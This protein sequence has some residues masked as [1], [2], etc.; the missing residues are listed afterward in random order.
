M[1]ARQL[2]RKHIAVHNS[3]NG[4]GIKRASE[5]PKLTRPDIDD[6]I[7][8]AVIDAFNSTERPEPV[9]VATRD[10]VKEES[11]LLEDSPISLL[12]TAKEPSTQ[13]LSITDEKEPV[14]QKKQEYHSAS[15]PT[16][17]EHQDLLSDNLA[18]NH[19]PNW[20]AAR[21]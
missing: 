1:K 13:A 15:I 18:S 8:S 10:L 11:R 17:S 21:T 12:K 16:T 4:L 7:L 6:S 19:H 5:K 9:H 3:V 20:L 2:R 14:A